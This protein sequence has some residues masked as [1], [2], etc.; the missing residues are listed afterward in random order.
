MLILHFETPLEVA[1]P[2]ACSLHFQFSAFV[3]FS[4]GC[5]PFCPGGTCWTHCKNSSNP[6]GP[7]QRKAIWGAQVCKFIVSL[8]FLIL[9]SFVDPSQNPTSPFFL[10]SFRKNNLNNPHFLLYL[11]KIKL[12]EKVLPFIKSLTW[13]SLTRRSLCYYWFTRC[14]TPRPDRRCGAGM[15]RQHLPNIHIVAK[16]PS[17]TIARL[18]LGFNDQLFKASSFPL[19]RWHPRSCGEGTARAKAA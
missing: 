10:V 16:N 6:M 13:P 17:G 2:I 3:W 9:I 8:V 5:S 14:S 12:L 4:L 15:L 7:V 18:S 19:P 11:K 1:N